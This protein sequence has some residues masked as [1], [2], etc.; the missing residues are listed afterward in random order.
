VVAV[1]VK[2][3]RLRRSLRDCVQNRL[4]EEQA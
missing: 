1:R 2:L 4:R 3:H